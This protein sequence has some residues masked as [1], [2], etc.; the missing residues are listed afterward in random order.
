MELLTNRTDVPAFN[1]PF[2]KMSTTLIR[3]QCSIMIYNIHLFLFNSD[4]KFEMVSLKFCVM[5]FPRL[6]HDRM[7]VGCSKM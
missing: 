4:D 3:K 7:N 5:N 1:R 6:G 2:F